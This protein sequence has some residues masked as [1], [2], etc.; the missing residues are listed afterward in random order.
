MDAQGDESL[1]RPEK[2]RRMEAVLAR[3]VS[4]REDKFA[5]GVVIE[6]AREGKFAGLLTELQQIDGRYLKIGM[7]EG[8]PVYRQEPP[9]EADQLNGTELFLMRSDKDSSPT[10][11][12]IICHS[13]ESDRVDR[14]G[15]VVAWGR[16]RTGEPHT[17]PVEMHFP[18]WIK[19]AHPALTVSSYVALSL[20]HI[21]RCR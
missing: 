7:L 13:I 4:S 10:K 19:K 1:D 6:V 20:I 17:L 5:E 18:F 14:K 8:S 9:T 3:R 16:A 15:N 21:R 2:R 11:G 12:W